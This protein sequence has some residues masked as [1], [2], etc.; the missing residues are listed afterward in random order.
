MEQLEELSAEDR[1]NVRARFH[2]FSQR[3]ADHEQ[4]DALMLAVNPRNDPKG[5][6]YREGDPSNASPSTTS[7]PQPPQNAD[8]NPGPLGPWK[9]P[10]PVIA[11][12]RIDA[13][14]TPTLTEVNP[15]QG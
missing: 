15:K 8:P 5:G 4:N 13:E 11:P 10:N 14:P 9:P 7:P 6:Q 3:N 2:D 12:P 1:R